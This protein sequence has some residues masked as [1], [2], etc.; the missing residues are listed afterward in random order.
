MNEKCT[1]RSRV[2]QVEGTCVHFTGIGDDD[3]VCAA[4]IAYVSV[5]DDSSRPFAWPCMTWTGAATT[6]A[7]ATYPSKEQA[8]REIREID[9]E[10][11][12][13]DALLLSGICPDCETPI[14]RRRVTGNCIYADPCGHR[15]GQHDNR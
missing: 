9:D 2:E 8:E 1:H 14:Q 13:Q 4:G 15:L 7:R 6:C 12:R 5:R 10:I 3:A 11:A